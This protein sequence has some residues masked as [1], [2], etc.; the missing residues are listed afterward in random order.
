MSKIIQILYLIFI[1]LT[2]VLIIA[3]SLQ[4]GPLSNLIYRSSITQRGDYWHAGFRMV[5]QNPIF[6]VGLDSYGDWYRFFRSPEAADRFRGSVVSNSAHNVFIDIAATAGISALIGYL[7]LITFAFRAS[8]KY[9]L[10]NNELDPFFIGVFAA[11][12]GYL[13]Q[14]IISINNIGLGIWGWVLPGVLISWSRT[15]A[16]IEPNS[17][18]LKEKRNQ[19]KTVKKY[20][21]ICLIGHCIAK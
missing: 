11:W 7:L 10:A 19:L 13:A 16:R 15:N 5:S 6:G 21:E 1:G 20:I 8:W 4:S 17:K 9:I 3:G 18:N 2:T 14:S 12:I